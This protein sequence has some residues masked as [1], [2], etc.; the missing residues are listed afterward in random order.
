M[1]FIHQE[2]EKCFILAL[3]SNRLVA[4]SLAD[5]Q[6]GRYVHIDTLA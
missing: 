3:K 6:Q 4:L 2:L 1:K 5:K